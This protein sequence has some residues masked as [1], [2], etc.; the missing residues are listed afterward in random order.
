MEPIEK[1]E[2]ISYRR[3]VRKDALAACEIDRGNF[4]AWRLREFA[5]ISR[6][7]AGNC[8]IAELNNRLVGFIAFTKEPLIGEIHRLVVEHRHRRLGIGTGLLNCAE[9]AM[10]Q[11]QTQLY[12]HESEVEMQ[13]F[14]RDKGF[15]GRILEDDR[16]F[17]LFTRGLPVT[18]PLGTYRRFSESAD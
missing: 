5:Q 4:E 3:M 11:R 15:T 8:I 9:N 16:A 18:I 14:L 1:I 12:V 2:G 6:P 17:M 7:G 10:P 13:L